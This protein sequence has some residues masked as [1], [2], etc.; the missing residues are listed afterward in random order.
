MRRFLVTP[1]PAAKSD[2]LVIPA[3]T[4]KSDA[5]VTP[6]TTAN[7]DALVTPAPTAKSD[8]CSIVAAANYVS[9]T[10]SND[11]SAAN[12]SIPTVAVAAAAAAHTDAK[13]RHNAT[14]VAVVPA[15]FLKIT[16]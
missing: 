3:P 6:A 2:A 7:S 11:V 10:G 4:A 13:L 15:F 12:K 16:I 8:A 5:L 9:T 14:T 1:A